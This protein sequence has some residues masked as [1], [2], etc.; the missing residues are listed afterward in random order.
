MIGIV[1]RVWKLIQPSPQ[2]RPIKAARYSL[3]VFQW[4]YF[5]S[6]ILISALI[7][8]TLARGDI[9]DDGHDLQLRLVSLPPSVLM[10]FLASLTLLSLI[11]NGLQIKLPFR[12]G[13]VEAGNVLRPAIYYIVEDVVSVD[14]CGKL[15]YREA[16][17]ARYESSHTFRRIITILSV[18]WTTAFFSIA[19]ALTFLIF[20]LPWQVVYPVG[21]V[22]PFPLAGILALWTIWYVKSMLRKERESDQASEEPDER[23]S[24]LS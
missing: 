6:L 8:S 10:Y 16:F 22:A 2:F 18:V 11:L 9:D 23:T 4:G 19:I 24:L 1:E 14:G 3:D 13:S 15:E 20:N 17:N 12:F 21:W 5:A 7:S